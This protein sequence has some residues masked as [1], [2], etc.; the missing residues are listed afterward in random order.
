MEK[1]FVVFDTD[2]I[3]YSSFRSLSDA[4]YYLDSM[5]DRITKN[6]EF[7]NIG[8]AGKRLWYTDRF[9]EERHILIKESILR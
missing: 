4:I 8:R 6:P 9:N 3:V 2:G 1:I 5:Q 7:S